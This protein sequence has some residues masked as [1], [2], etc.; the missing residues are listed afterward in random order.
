MQPRLPIKFAGTLLLSFV[1]LS[2]LLAP[3]SAS[4]AS[5]MDR[6]TSTVRG[7][8]GTDWISLKAHP[9]ATQL[10]MVDVARTTLVATVIDLELDEFRPMRLDIVDL[11]GNVVKIL[12]DG[13]W[14]EGR[15][16]MAWYHEN[17]D[18]EVLESGTY[19]VRLTPTL[20]ATEGLALVR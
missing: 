15:H 16:Q 18:D 9:A 10:R 4:E 19:V 20:G 5:G 2:V 6:A 13:L 12:A 3:S 14:A 17:E 11:D 7:P 1:V 8:V